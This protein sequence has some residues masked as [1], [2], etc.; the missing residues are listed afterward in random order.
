MKTSFILFLLALFF[1]SSCSV[2]KVSDSKPYHENT[3]KTGT[4]YLFVKADNSKINAKLDS[5]STVDF[6]VTNREKSSLILKR[7]EYPVVKKYSVPLTLAIPAGV[8][9]GAYI[10]TAIG[11]QQWSSGWN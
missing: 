11:L 1:I 9:V 4:N 2:T 10:I 3:L 7:E 5:V 8:L 6:Y